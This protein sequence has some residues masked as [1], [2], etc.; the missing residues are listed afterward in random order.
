MSTRTYTTTLSAHSS[1]WDVASQLLKIGSVWARHY[2]FVKLYLTIV[3]Y[4]SFQVL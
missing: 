2:C 1:I 3:D 4:F